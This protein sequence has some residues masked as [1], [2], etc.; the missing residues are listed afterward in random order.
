M[1]ANWRIGS[2][3]GI[4]L[5]INSSWFVILAFVTLVNANDV[6]AMELSGLSPALGWLTG[7]GMALLLFTSVLL[8]ELGHSLVARSQGITVNSITLFLFGGIASIERESKTPSE[9][10]SVAIAGPMVSLVLCGLFF[11]LTTLSQSLPLLEFLASD[12]AKINLVIALFNL[13]PG[14]PLDGGQVLKAIVW[15]IS[16][17]RFTGVRWAS[18]SG[19]LL[20]TLGI[21][22]G[23]LLVLLTGE[24]GAIWLSLIGWFVLQN[25][26]A[27]NRLTLIQQSLLELTAADAMSRDFRVVNANLT[28]REFIEEYI[29]SQLG[30]GISQTYYAASEGRYRGLLR[31]SQIQLMERSEWDNK[32]LIDIVHPLTEIASVQEKTPLVQVVKTLDT[33]KDPFLTVLSLAG[34]VAGVIDR[35]DVIQAIA[36]HNKLSI[37][38]AEI[39]RIKAEKTYPSYLQLGAIAKTLVPQDYAQTQK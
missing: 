22:F 26:K 11:A 38:E 10:F 37:P 21:S 13:I 32:H 16:G 7:L 6:N 5:Y 8:H 24:I 9:A 18:A 39:K 27:Y 12:L 25:A 31:V 34:A 4:P 3:F 14:L 20:G 1:R 33:I 28:L 35:A 36:A 15:K 30:L 23:L 17:D 2:L 29:I 19:Q